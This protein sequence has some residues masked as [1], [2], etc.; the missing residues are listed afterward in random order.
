ME[1]KNKN[2]KREWKVKWKRE[3]EKTKKEMKDTKI[4]NVEYYIV[5]IYNKH[6]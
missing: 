1:R 3:R 2:G 5:K 4:E 6:P